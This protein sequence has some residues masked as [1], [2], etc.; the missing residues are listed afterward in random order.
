M[1]PCAHEE[2][3]EQETGDKITQERARPSVSR[4]PDPGVEV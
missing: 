3:K 1:E 4:V 2:N